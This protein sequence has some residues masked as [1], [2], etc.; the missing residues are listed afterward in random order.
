MSEVLIFTDIHIHRHKKSI[1]RIDDCLKVLD[2]IFDTAEANNI[3]HILF[4]GDL[5]H[6][7][8]KIDVLVYQKVFEIFLKR[9][10]TDRDEPLNIHLLIG[11]HD[12]YHRDRWDINSVSPLNAIPGVNVIDEPK[13]IDILGH[14]FDFMPHAENP[15][16]G[17]T[18]FK[19]KRRYLCAHLAVH[20]ATLNSSGM[21][22]DVIVEHDGEM[23]KVD[24][25]CF[26]KWDHTFLGHYHAQQQVADNVEYIGSPLQLNF[27]E[28]FQ[29]KHICIFNPETGE[30]NYVAN[31]FSPRH[32]VIPQV[33]IEKYNL[34]GNFVRV[35]VDDMTSPDVL[36]MHQGLR[37]ESGASS[38]ELKPS[39]KKEDQQHLITDA[40]AIL[41]NEEEML[42]KYLED[43]GIGEL[44]EKKLLAIGTTICEGAEESE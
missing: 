20:G 10:L 30:R 44:N 33:D 36:E 24:K 4:L 23:V 27:G 2:W 1:N 32:L 39:R 19:G 18:S 12:M 41:Y 13:T 40:K 14:K 16:D 21:E 15:M 31:E 6:D 38:L 7:R 28:S 11:N 42:E 29:T 3:E 22:A 37:N 8:Q 35:V 5:F 17:L 43:V 25:D 26:S 9:Q 34:E